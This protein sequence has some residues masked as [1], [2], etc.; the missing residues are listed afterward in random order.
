[1]M[2]IITILQHASSND[3]VSHEAHKTYQVWHN[4]TPPHIMLALEIPGDNN[5]LVD[6]FHLSCYLD[7]D[8]LHV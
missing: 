4:M 6:T 5:I 2:P 3:G 8:N 1:M 7:I